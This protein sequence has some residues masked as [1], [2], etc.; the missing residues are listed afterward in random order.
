M[1]QFLAKHA[2][3]I[4]GALT[5]FDRIIFKGYLPISSESGVKNFFFNN[6]WLIKDFK[7]LAPQFSAQIADF[8]KKTCDAANRPFLYPLAHERKE[9]LAREIAERDQLTS[10][11]VCVCQTMEPCGSFKV[12]YGKERPRLKAQR[13]KCRFFYFYYMDREF[14][15]MHVRLQSWLPFPIQ[16]YVN[17]HEWLAKKMTRHGID[18]R[19]IDNAFITIDDLPRAQ[20]FANNLARKNWVNILH[21]FAKRI[22]PLLKTLFKGMEYYWVCDQSEVATDVIF[23]DRA[24]LKCLY[25]KL[26]RHATLCFSAE[27][28]LIFLG[29]KLHGNFTG[30]ALTD[31]KVRERGARVKHRVKGNWIKMY[32]KY[33]L[34]LRIETVI[35]QPREFKVF[36]R[37]KR[38]GELLMG[39]FPMAKRVT[40]LPRYYELS[41]RACGRYLDALSVV[42]DPRSAYGELRLLTESRMRQGRRARGLNPLRRDDSRLFSCV[43]RGEHMINGFRNKDIV[44]H[45]FLVSPRDKVVRR[46]RRRKVTRLLGILRTHGLIARIPRSR[47]YRVTQ[48]GRSVMSSCVFMQHEMF[49][50]KLAS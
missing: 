12:A 13:R 1:K 23:K 40:N 22:N 7:K 41:V 33:G 16:I 47:R 9:A 8:A 17:G 25:E 11:L 42:A 36:R 29:K 24:S 46:Q 4:R 18:Y 50:E 31:Y 15:L 26:L 35:N 20:R 5:C 14:G 38:A 10:G 3:S 45:F 37:G 28:V 6:N 19:K 21:S 2:K 39:W 32:D 48:K 30:E 34:V 44:R 43:L 27:D 49:P